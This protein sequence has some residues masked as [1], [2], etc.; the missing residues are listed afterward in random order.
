MWR[1][2]AVRIR[3]AAGNYPSSRKLTREG[4]H[5]VQGVTLLMEFTVRGDTARPRGQECPRHTGLAICPR[6]GAQYLQVAP[7]FAAGIT[8]EK[9]RHFP[10]L[11][12]ILLAVQKYGRL[13]QPRGLGPP[14]GGQ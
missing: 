11:P 10:P 7:A 1:R 8:V 3:L 4:E 9:K 13:Q 14:L 6:N 5:S 2:R 12:S